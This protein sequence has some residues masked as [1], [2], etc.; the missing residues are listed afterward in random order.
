MMLGKRDQ[1]L[2]AF[3]HPRRGHGADLYAFAWD[4][5]DTVMR[6]DMLSLAR[7]IIGEVQRFP[8]IGRAYQAAAR[9]TGVARASCAI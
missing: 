1:M 9:T 4:Y 8:E 5:A 6:P 2:D 7:L 3:E